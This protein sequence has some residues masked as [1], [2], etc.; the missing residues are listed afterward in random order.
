MLYIYIHYR[1]SLCIPDVLRSDVLRIIQL[2]TNNIYATVLLLR[3]QYTGVD[4]T[5]PKF[6]G[7]VYPRAIHASSKHNHR[8]YSIISS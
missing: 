6:A 7:L 3:V 8:P 1:S 5:R 2:H 4:P